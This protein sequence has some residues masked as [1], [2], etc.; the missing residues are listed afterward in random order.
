M[1]WRTSPRRLGRATLKSNGLQ[2]SRD[3]HLLRQRLISHCSTQQERF[4]FGGRWSPQSATFSQDGWCVIL[5]CFRERRCPNCAYRSET[6]KVLRKKK[7]CDFLL[8]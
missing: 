7:G 3:K 8:R 1:D 4:W 5:T 6:M 2:N